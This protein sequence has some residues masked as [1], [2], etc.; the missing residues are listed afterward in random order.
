MRMK[1]LLWPL[2]SGRRLVTIIF[3]VFLLSGLLCNVA[4]AGGNYFFTYCGADGKCLDVG[5]Y[6]S[7]RI[8]RDWLGSLGCEHGPR[9]LA[10]P[11]GNNCACVGPGVADTAGGK[12]SNDCYTLGFKRGWYHIMPGT[13]T[14]IRENNMGACKAVSDECFAIGGIPNTEGSKNG[15]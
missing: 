13:E 2:F 7:L 5:N 4:N 10:D 1:K 3:V 9:C 6:P 14:L 12:V 11:T 8:C 15:P